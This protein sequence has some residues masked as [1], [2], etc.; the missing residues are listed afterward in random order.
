MYGRRA[1]PVPLNPRDPDQ[2]LAHI[3]ANAQ[4]SVLIGQGDSSSTKWIDEDGLRWIDITHANELFGDV[5]SLEPISVD[6]PALVLYTSG[7]TGQPKGVV[8]SQRSLLQRVQ[9]YADACHID[10][11]DVFMPLSGPTTIAGTRE[12]LT[13][14]L[15]GARLHMADVE[16]LG[17]RGVLRQI[18]S[19]QITITYIVPAL[20]RAV[21]TASE[22]GDF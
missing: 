9:Q 18:R 13:A 14:L 11:T 12:M 2:R 17:L 15:T 8:N 19:Q 21:I 16:A 7:S 3:V 4:I 20:L 10:A 5:P 22:T 1:P 6:A